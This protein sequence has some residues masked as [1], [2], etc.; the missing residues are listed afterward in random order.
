MYRRDLAIPVKKKLYIDLIAHAPGEYVVYFDTNLHLT[1]QTLAPGFLQPDSD[2][3]LAKKL[4]PSLR[5]LYLRDITVHENNWGLII[6]YLAHQTSGGQRISLTISSSEGP[7]H[8][9]RD[10]LKEMRGLVRELV[11]DLTLDDDCPLDRC[12]VSREEE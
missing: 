11:L 2:A 12:S 5:R 9:C 3:P 6:P 8:I 4:L 10:V 7:W 1:G